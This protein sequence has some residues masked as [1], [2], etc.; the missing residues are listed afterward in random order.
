V[1]TCN[2]FILAMLTILLVGCSQAMTTPT[3]TAPPSTVTPA[4]ATVVV[5][6]TPTL[7][8]TTEHSGG[9]SVGQIAFYSHRDGNIEI[10]TMRP[11][12]SNQRRL[13]VNEYDDYSPAWS[14]DGARIAFLSDRDD[15]NPTQCAHEC[16]YQLYVINADGS[17][18]HKL[19]ETEFS[20]H[21]PDWHPDG[22]KLSFDTEF[23]LQGDI[24]VVNADGSGLQ[25]LIED[26][27]WADWSP[28]G[29]QIVFASKRDGNVE[30]YAAD[31]NG[32]NQRRLTENTRLDFF[33]AWSPD[34]RRI[35]FATMEQKQIFVMDADGGNEQQVTYQGKCEDPAWSPDG[36]Q[37]AFQSSSDGNFEIY[38]INVE[39]AL[40]ESGSVGSQ[41]L[42]DNPK[43]DLWPSWGPAAFQ[44]AGEPDGPIS[45]TM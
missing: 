29:A 14:P 30:I 37:I 16:F 8:V 22:T 34:G 7:T 17:D 13:T 5:T 43:G 40:Q 28:D 1:H 42:T 4:Q 15:A 36:R 25:L 2:K 10:Y 3:A 20:V 41:R 35:A 45:G 26:G 24:Y 27:F 6:S 31:A 9:L 12:G 11:D 38:T 18:E 19:V 21:H 33:P 23:N 32:S 39:D 44:G